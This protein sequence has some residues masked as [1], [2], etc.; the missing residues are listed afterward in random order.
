MLD[1]AAAFFP[2]IRPLEKL[3][4]TM[5]F[6]AET[7][8][9][10]KSGSS[11]LTSKTICCRVKRVNLIASRAF[12]YKRVSRILAEQITESVKWSRHQ[13]SGSLEQATIIGSSRV[14]SGR[15]EHF[16]V[17]KASR[18]PGRL[19]GRSVLLE[20]RQVVGLFFLDVL[21]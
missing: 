15:G 6:S 3:S 5:I 18:E 10:I 13:G 20:Q 2:I 21:V 7:V 1:P 17:V 9:C 16:R 11:L 12:A 8:R 4:Y 14:A 19:V